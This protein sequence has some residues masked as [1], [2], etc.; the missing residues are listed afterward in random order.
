MKKILIFT[1]LLGAI[2]FACYYFLINVTFDITAKL[3]ENDLL[4][5]AGDKASP[6][7]LPGDLLKNNGE[8][9][10]PENIPDVKQNGSTPDKTVPGEK[11]IGGKSRDSAPESGGTPPDKNT[12]INKGDDSTISPEKIAQEISFEDKKKIVNLVMSRLSRE[13]ISYLAGLARGGLTEEEKKAAVDLAYR[14]FTPQ[15][16]NEIKAYYVKY[17]KKAK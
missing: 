6:S 2:A 16:I 9:D 4:K 17:I 13:D 15:E 10:S 3:I 5:N 14:R 8:N 7:A 1:I 12:D 11:N